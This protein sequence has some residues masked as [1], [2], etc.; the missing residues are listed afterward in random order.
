MSINESKQAIDRAK[1]EAIERIQGL[2]QN[3]K[4]GSV[5]IDSVSFLQTNDH[6]QGMLILTKLPR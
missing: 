6:K 2:L 1:H 3:L 4:K 5:E